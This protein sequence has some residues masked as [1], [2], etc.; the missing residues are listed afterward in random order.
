MGPHDKPDADPPTVV[1]DELGAVA[2]AGA[3]A[4]RRVEVIDS[5]GDGVAMENASRRASCVCRAAT[6]AQRGDEQLTAAAT[7][8]LRE[9]TGAWARVFIISQ[10]L[11]IGVAARSTGQGNREAAVPSH[12]R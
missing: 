1:V 2:A 4:A 9:A 10:R 3:A 11:L 8:A 7:S 6:G 12:G 5:R